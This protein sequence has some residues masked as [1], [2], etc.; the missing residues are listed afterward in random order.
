M[1]LSLIS[2]YTFPLDS[3]KQ[4]SFH[5][6]GGTYFNYTT[7][8]QT[9]GILPGLD[10][11]NFDY[12][13]FMKDFW[14]NASGDRFYSGKSGFTESRTTS[15][16]PYF[17]ADLKLNKEAYNIVLGA[18]SRG[19]IARYSLDPKFN[20]KTFDNVVR[21]AASYTTKNEYEFESEIEY[22]FYNGYSDGFGKPEWIWNAGVSKNIG[23][24]SLS[25]NVHDILN[26]TRNLERTVNANYKEDTY[27]LVLGRYVLVGIKWNFGKMNATH[28]QRAQ[29][30][31][32]NMIY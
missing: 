28:S 14:G 16:Q 26:Q 5:I 6:G 19:Y 11:D 20:M 8:Y 27:R 18:T 15:F 3:K 31:A 25:L 1:T 4:W 13:D 7:S 30:A 29:E 17:V 23:A 22:N 10:K 9:K 2:H 24:F 12:S 21:L 32:W